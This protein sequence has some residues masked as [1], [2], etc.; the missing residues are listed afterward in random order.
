MVLDREGDPPMS[1]TPNLNSLYDQ[2]ILLWSE[3]EV[4]KD[5]LSNEKKG[6][7][8]SILSPI[9]QKNGSNHSLISQACQIDPDG[10]HIS[11]ASLCICPHPPTP[12]PKLGRRG[13]EAS[14]PSPKVERGI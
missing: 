13:V 6:A 7:E 1:Q 10:E 14:S 5:R 8:C 12:S 2:D 3:S 4:L 9:K 11:F